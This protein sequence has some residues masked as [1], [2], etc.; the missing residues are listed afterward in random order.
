MNS[1]VLV[2]LF[3]VFAAA[4]AGLLTGAPLVSAYGAA[5]VV[6]AY[7]AP[8]VGAGLVGEQ[9][10]VA[11]PSGTIATGRTLAAPAVSAYA[12]PALAAYSAPIVSPYAAHGVV[13]R[14]IW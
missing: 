6:S 12:A 11:G 7:S 1:F 4:N 2:A 10:V 5:P 8:L 13:A 9:T 3:A 14:T